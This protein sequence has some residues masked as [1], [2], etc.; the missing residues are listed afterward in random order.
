MT[1]FAW[2]SSPGG[3]GELPDVPEGAGITHLGLWVAPQGREHLKLAM[4]WHL[5]TF[6]EAP[7]QHRDNVD[8]SE[9]FGKD[10]TSGLCFFVL[11][12]KWL[13]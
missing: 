2:S 11:E 4:T 6:E 8:L 1:G 5:S 13:H 12:S 10:L 3:G 9:G 7:N